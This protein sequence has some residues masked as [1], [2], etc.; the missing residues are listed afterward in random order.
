MARLI[1]YHFGLVTFI[2]Q[3]R[4]PYAGQ[5]FQ[6]SFVRLLM[7]ILQQMLNGFYRAKIAY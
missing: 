7:L 3:D 4:F 6:Y 5:N 2:T 1:F